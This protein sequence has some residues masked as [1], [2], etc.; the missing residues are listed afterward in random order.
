MLTQRSRHLLLQKL[1]WNPIGA[2][3][4][5]TL[6]RYERKFDTVVRNHSLMGFTNGERWL[7]TRCFPTSSS[8]FSTLPVPPR[9]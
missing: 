3:F 9:V 2:S 4:V 5:H 1:F 6:I 7:L 8:S